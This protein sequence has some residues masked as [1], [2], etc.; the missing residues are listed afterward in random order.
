MEA[1]QPLLGL[2]FTARSVVDNLLFGVVGCWNIE[3]LE[4]Y[5][6]L[7]L[8]LAALPAGWWLWQSPQRRLMI[9][10]LGL[11]GGSYWLIYSARA[12]WDYE[13]VMTLPIWARYHLLPYLGLMLFFCGGLAGRPRWFRLREDGT[14]TRRQW[15]AVVALIVV[16]LF[17]HLPRG[18]NWAETAS[19]EQFAA[20]ESQLADLRSI[21]DMDARCRHYHISA[22]A[23]R[24]VLP[25]FTLTWS[26]D[27]INGWEFLRGS[28][29]P[30]PLPPQEVK[31]LLET[32]RD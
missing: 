23:A 5:V 15:W 3:I 2:R 16:C 13:G 19:G 8:A 28:D 9:L 14:L 22:D 24:Q 27:V 17:I 1:F 7:L 12:T 20:H 10:G 29:D 26:A 25:R 18:W 30:R 6:Y 11:M 32:A 31:R 21:E 4:P